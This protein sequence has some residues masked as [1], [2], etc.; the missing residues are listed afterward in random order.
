MAAGPAQPVAHR[1]VGLPWLAA[2]ADQSLAFKEQSWHGCEQESPRVVVS[3]RT[4]ASLSEHP[5]GVLVGRAEE[6]A[7][8]VARGRQ[9]RQRNSDSLQDLVEFL[10]R[11]HPAPQG[12]RMR[13]DGA[14]K[15]ERACEFDVQE[16]GEAL[17]IQG[18]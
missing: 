7:G 11:W 15:Y 5:D 16:Q 8:R 6:T 3:G 4:P 10:V 12:S 17:G 9:F 18:T 1:V 14:L 2:S 13:R